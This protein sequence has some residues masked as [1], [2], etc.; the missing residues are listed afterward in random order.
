M[1]VIFIHI[2]AF[3]KDEWDATQIGI[4]SLVARRKFFTTNHMHVRT[5]THKKNICGYH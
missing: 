2:D 3:C 1:I 5:S 4:T